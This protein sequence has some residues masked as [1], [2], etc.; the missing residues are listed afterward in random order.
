MTIIAIYH[1]EG[2]STINLDTVTKVEYDEST[3]D[4]LFWTPASV[5]FRYHLGYKDGRE[6]MAAYMRALAPTYEGRS[7]F[8]HAV[9]C[10]LDLRPWVSR[11]AP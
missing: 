1:P 3:G 6:V 8:T 11:M 5:P 7:M 2:N 9:R 10:D 4:L